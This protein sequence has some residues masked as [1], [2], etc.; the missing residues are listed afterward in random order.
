MDKNFIIRDI[1]A[2]MVIIR[3][4]NSLNYPAFPFINI[5]ANCLF[6]NYLEGFISHFFL[7][8]FVWCFW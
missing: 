1:I 4:C 2:V 5:V 3:G 8:E 6:V 7:S